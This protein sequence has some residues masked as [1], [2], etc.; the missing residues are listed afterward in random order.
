MQCES[1]SLFCQN[2]SQL[3]ELYRFH[4]DLA[5][6]EQPGEEFPDLEALCLSNCTLRDTFLTLVLPPRF[7]YHVLRQC[8]HRDSLQGQNLLKE[9]R[10]ES[11]LQYWQECMR[12]DTGQVALGT[13]PWLAQMERKVLLDMHEG[14]FYNKANRLW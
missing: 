3:L 12:E 11:Q 2:Y 9:T 10:S 14:V 4:T 13:A 6:P 8:L 7:R 5:E 1:R